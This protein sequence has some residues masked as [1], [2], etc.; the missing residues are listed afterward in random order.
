MVIAR[1][2]DRLAEAFE[3]TLALQERFKEISREERSKA[4]ASRKEG[5]PRR[6]R[7]SKQAAHIG[8]G[9]GKPRG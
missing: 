1:Q 8:G 7:P 3:T 9:K 5:R 2:W 4:Q 6:G